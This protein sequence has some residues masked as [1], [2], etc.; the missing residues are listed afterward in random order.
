[1]KFFKKLG[2]GAKRLGRKLEKGFN[3]V[4]SFGRK[5]MKG[6]DELGVGDVLRDVGREA[7]RIGQQEIQRATGV[8]VG[9]V[10]RQGQRAV[11]MARRAGN[12]NLEQ[13]GRQVGTQLA[14]QGGQRLADRLRRM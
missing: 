13:L 11:D 2:E 5:V 7:G 14:R 9:N 3:T 8:D 10:V 1:M 4:K 12:V 6:A